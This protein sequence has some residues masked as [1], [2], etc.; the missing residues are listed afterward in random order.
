MRFLPLKESTVDA[1]E[2]PM[3]DDIQEMLACSAPAET[4]I[5]PTQIQVKVSLAVLQ[6]LAEKVDIPCGWA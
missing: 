5:K 6:A 1:N 2:P 3:P 4:S